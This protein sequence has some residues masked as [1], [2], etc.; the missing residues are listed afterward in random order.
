[1]IVRIVYAGSNA[2]RYFSKTPIRITDV[3]PHP[4]VMAI[5]AVGAA[6]LRGL[7]GMKILVGVG[8]FGMMTLAA[9]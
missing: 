4:T 6:G 5:A 8:V 2:M 9:L 1:M 3:L 7:E